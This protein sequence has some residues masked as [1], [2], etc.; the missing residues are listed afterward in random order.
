MSIYRKALLFSQVLLETLF[1]KLITW[2]IYYHI[3]IY[4]PMAIILSMTVKENL[5]QI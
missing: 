2:D 4:A 5:P 1:V 3:Y